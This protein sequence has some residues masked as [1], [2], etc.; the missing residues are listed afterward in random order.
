MHHDIRT[1]TD[2]LEKI[3]RIYR[4]MPPSADTACDKGC[5]TCCTRN[6]TLTTLEA[7]FLIEGSAPDLRSELLKTIASA[8]DGK[9]LIPAVTI[10]TMAELCMEGRELPEEECDPSWGPCP[11]LQNS[12]CPVYTKRPFACR[13]MV[14]S[15]VC[16]ATGFADMDDYTVTVNNVMMQYIEHID[17]GGFTGNYSDM[18]LLMGDEKN[19]RA[20]EEGRLQIPESGFVAN[21]P[22]KALMVPPEHRDRI[23]P[24]LE[25]LNAP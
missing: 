22:V 21:R 15:A 8:I 3:Y 9:R 20:Y 14:S 19:R 13:C 6:V 1:R 12:V 5:A 4:E 23:R 11:V 10:N 25:A 2:A 24:V 7:F 17:A 18:L 16:S